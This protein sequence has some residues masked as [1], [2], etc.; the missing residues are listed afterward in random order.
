MGNIRPREKQI[1]YMEGLACDAGCNESVAREFG[2]GLIQ[3]AELR[4]RLMEEVQKLVNA[5]FFA[6]SAQVKGTDAEF[7]VSASFVH[8]TTG[9]QEIRQFGKKF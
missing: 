4:E 8:I 5:Q 1:D 3:E 2:E 9:L 7:L 6:L